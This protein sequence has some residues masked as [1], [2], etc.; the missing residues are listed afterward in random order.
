[1]MRS[2]ALSF[3]L[4][5]G[6][7]LTVSFLAPAT[8]FAHADTASE[9]QAQIDAHNAKIK[10][11]ENEIAAYQKT[12]NILSTTKQTLQSTIQTIDVSRTQTAAQIN[13]T[14]KKIAAANLKLKELTLEIGTKELSIKVDKET[15]ASTLRTIAQHDSTS[16]V[17]QL[18]SSEDL[19]TAWSAIDRDTSVNDALRQHAEDL[20]NVKQQLDAQHTQVSS[21]KTNLTVLNSDLTTQKQTLDANRQA[22]SSL[23]AQTKNQ[24]SS[25]QSLLAKKRSEQKVFEAELSALENSLKSVGASSIPRA[26]SG[27]LS[28]PTTPHLV[29][30]AF[31]NTSFAASGA[32]NGNG[33][34]GID[35][36]VPIGTPI[37][38]ALSGVV[39]G[40]GNTDSVSGCYSFGKW[41]AIK[42]TNGL[43]TVYA[44]LSSVGV[45]VGQ[46]VSTGDIIG[47]SGMTGYATGPHLHFGVYAVGTPDAPGIQIQTLAAFKGSRTPCANATMPVAPTNAYLDPMTFL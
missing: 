8:P 26:S 15:V 47:F 23:L 13:A 19:G 6:T 11:I 18:L 37:K 43:A 16:I 4:L 10:E 17:E 46:A 42:H 44:H 5:F 1:M 14:N 25:F 31:G 3:L 30:Q 24:E 2:I 35:I 22:K 41:I 45:S 34:N 32:Y 9:L 38:T 20:A 12:L 33:H 7:L 40:A 21:T 39:M 36:G 27:T 29:T 28:W